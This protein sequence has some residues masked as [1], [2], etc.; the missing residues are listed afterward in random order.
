MVAQWPFEIA[1][2]MSKLLLL[3]ATG[4]VGQQV[5]AQALADSAVA[6]VVAPTRRPLAPHPKL[7]NPVVDFKALPQAGW[8]AAD[9]VV[10]CLGTT[11]KLAGSPA[12][13][14]EVDHDHVLAAARLARAAGTPSFA[15]NSSLGAAASSGNLYLRTKGE[16]EDAL[17]AL[18][19]TSLTLVRPSLLDGGPRPDT[20]PGEAVGL[21]FA[22]VAHPLIPARYRAVRTEAVAWVLLQAA[23][24]AKPGRHVV[25]NADI[26]A[27]PPITSAP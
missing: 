15:L 2:T 4:L 9:A 21:W 11:L 22:R 16:T 23:R 19:F 14:R 17:A 1:H 18:G 3:G 13:F 26:G 27:A 6:L 5:L 12:A 10:C 24:Q 20:R 25:L 8:W 7:L